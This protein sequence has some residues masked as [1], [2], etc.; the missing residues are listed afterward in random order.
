MEEQIIFAQ[1]FRV[2]LCE[3]A[4]KQQ[5]TGGRVQGEGGGE[6]KPLHAWGEIGRGP[7]PASD[8]GLC[9]PDHGSSDSAVHGWG[10]RAKPNASD[11]ASFV[12][13]N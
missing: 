6:C 7:K 9:A 5:E 2:K 11:L 4:C 1:N 10:G 12:S 3:V 13:I 8:N